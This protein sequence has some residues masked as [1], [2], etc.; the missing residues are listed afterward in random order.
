MEIKRAVLFI[1]VCAMT[2][3]AG[4]AGYSD[5]SLYSQDIKSIYIEMFDNATFTR[6]IEY[7]L[8]DAIAKRIDTDTPYRIVSDKSRA[9][10]VLSGKVTAISGLPL[11]IER[12]TARP[13]ASQS[14]VSAI[15]SWKNLN[16]GEYLL[17]NSSA[18]ATASYSEFQ[19]QS[20]DYASKVA[21]NKLAE[22]IVEQMQMGW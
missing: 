11:T 6:D 12:E 16:T 21:A 15:F 1:S 10:T 22:R 9:D 18:T 7:D 14:E 20:F 3:F 8:T 13:L 5:E 19:E 2:A 4:C 17:E